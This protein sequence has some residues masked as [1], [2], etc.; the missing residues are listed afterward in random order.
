LAR[1]STGLR[2]VGAGLGCFYSALT[3][4]EFRRDVGPSMRC[5]NLR[6]R[7]RGRSGND[8]VIFAE[9]GLGHSEDWNRRCQPEPDDF[10]WTAWRNN[11]NG[12]GL[13]AWTFGGLPERILGDL[14]GR[15]ADLCMA[16]V[17]G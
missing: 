10:A 14:H 1:V 2:F 13:E 9:P 15:G 12:P 8:K 6:P 16:G 17:A 4:C 5:R 7:M 3:H 11:G